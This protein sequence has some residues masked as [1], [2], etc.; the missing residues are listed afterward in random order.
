MVFFK[1]DGMPSCHAVLLIDDIACTSNNPFYV[2]KFPGVKELI[3]ALPLWNQSLNSLRTDRP[4][5]QPI[6]VKLPL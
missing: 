1:T 5:K 6:D 3:S 4:I 2:G